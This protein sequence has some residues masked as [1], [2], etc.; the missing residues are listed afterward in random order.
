M[1][2][3]RSSDHCSGSLPSDSHS[4]WLCSVLTST[5]S[6]LSSWLLGVGSLVSPRPFGL[7]TKVDLPWCV[8]AKTLQWCRT[9]RDPVVYSLPGFSVHPRQEYS[10]G[11]PCSPPGYLPDP[12][13]RLM[14]L[15][16][17]AFSGRFFTTSTTWEAQSTFISP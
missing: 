10:S 5:P 6:F 16:S 3:P 12:E 11:L 14:S 15:M 9:L 13:I 7:E 4:G 17:P 2:Q 1:L 8:R